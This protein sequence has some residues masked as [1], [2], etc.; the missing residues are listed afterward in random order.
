MQ[1]KEKKILKLRKRVIFLHKKIEN[2]V[3]LQKLM[4]LRRELDISNITFSRSLK[5]LRRLGELG[6][7]GFSE[8]ESN[9]IVEKEFGMSWDE[10]MYGTPLEL[11]NKKR[12]NEIHETVMNTPIVKEALSKHSKL[13]MLEKEIKSDIFGRC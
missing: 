2:N 13:R 10:I 1:R 12:H 6:N 7:L 4:E 8:S 5:C 9:V 11:E 3:E